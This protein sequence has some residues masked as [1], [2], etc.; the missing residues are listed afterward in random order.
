MSIALEPHRVPGLVPSPEPASVSPPATQPS[1][2]L[3]SC[4]RAHL[5]GD[6][7]MGGPLPEPRVIACHKSSL[8]LC[9]WERSEELRS[10]CTQERVPR[11][12]T[13]PVAT[14]GPHDASSGERSGPS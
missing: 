14:P 10:L 5:A 8:S 4:Q 6:R 3:P 1:P 13:L 7:A 12:P 11:D 9:S 2:F